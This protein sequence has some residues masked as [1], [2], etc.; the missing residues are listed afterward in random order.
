MNDKP[1]HDKDWL[2]YELTRKSMNQIAREQGVTTR[3]VSYFKDKFGLEPAIVHT[4][5][6]CNAEYVN[7]VSNSKYCSK[8]CKNRSRKRYRCKYHLNE[9]LESLKCILEDMELY[10]EI[11]EVSRKLFTT[12]K[13]RGI[14][15]GR[16]VEDVMMCCI[17]VAL[18]SMGEF[19]SREWFKKFLPIT[20]KVRKILSEVYAIAESMGITPKEINVDKMI[21]VYCERLS[22]DAMPVKELY[23]KINFRLGG[24]GLN[25][26]IAGFIYYYSQVVKNGLTQREISEKCYCNA[27]SLRTHYRAI[28]EV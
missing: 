14:I 22:L 13:V 4:C 25:G 5:V 1:Y 9:Y 16:V 12:L 17:I 23:K 24:R 15:K 18:R 3:A 2:D 6:S 8:K 21:E 20:H 7:N 10:E 28:R 11:G 27:V 26:V 19:R